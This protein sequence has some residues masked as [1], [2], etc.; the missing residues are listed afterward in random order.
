MLPGVDEVNGVAE[1]TVGQNAEAFGQRSVGVVLLSV[2]DVVEKKV[3][4]KFVA[5]EQKRF[6]EI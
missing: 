6:L 3:G 5:Y 1:K 4:R 2:V